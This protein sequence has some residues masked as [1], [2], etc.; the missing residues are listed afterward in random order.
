M[1]ACEFVQLLATTSMTISVMMDRVLESFSRMSHTNLPARITTHVPICAPL[2]CYTRP[3][4][5]VFG[6][7][8]LEE[9]K[10]S[11]YR[12][13][14]LTKTALATTEQKLAFTLKQLKNRLVN[15][16]RM[17]V[18]FVRDSHVYCTQKA[19]T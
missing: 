3:C 9:D 16:K 12:E 1:Y 13:L 14:E 7:Q 5:S 11:N 17:S 4:T 18:E 10:D 19:G 15:N 6:L 8:S 2:S